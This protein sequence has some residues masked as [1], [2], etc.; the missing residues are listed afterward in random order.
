MG[1]TLHYRCI[2][3]GIFQSEEYLNLLDHLEKPLW[4]SRKSKIDTNT[5]L[6]RLKDQAKVSYK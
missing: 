5:E 2:C 6:E 4:N 1:V 3:R